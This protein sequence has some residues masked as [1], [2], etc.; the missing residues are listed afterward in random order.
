[1]FLALYLAASITTRHYCLALVVGVGSQHL[2]ADEM[3]ASSV[4]FRMAARYGMR[5]V[6]KKPLSDVFEKYIS[7]N[8]GRGLIGRMQALEVGNFLKTSLVCKLF[9]CVSDGNHV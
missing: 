3:F 8:E 6:Y 1:M 7:E 9:F 4:F 5:L 2:V